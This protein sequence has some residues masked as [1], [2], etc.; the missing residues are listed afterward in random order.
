V[1]VL[2]VF[3][4]CLFFHAQEGYAVFS[5][6]RKYQR[7]KSQPGSVAMKVQWLGSDITTATLPMLPRGGY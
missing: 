2:S 1:D 5:Q 4:L 6:K 3:R 7:K